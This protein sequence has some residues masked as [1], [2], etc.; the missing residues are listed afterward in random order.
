MRQH[1]RICNYRQKHMFLNYSFNVCRFDIFSQGPW[2]YGEN[3]SVRKT[4]MHAHTHVHAHTG[5]STGN[6]RA[7]SG[8][9]GEA[10]GPCLW[11]AA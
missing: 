8:S 10:G 6:C 1:L 11:L 7:A 2:G 3:S 4:H 9:L 5:S